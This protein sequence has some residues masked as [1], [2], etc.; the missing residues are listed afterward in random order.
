M[1]KG[2]HLPVGSSYREAFRVMATEQVGPASIWGKKERAYYG[3]AHD[4]NYDIAVSRRKLKVTGTVRERTVAKAITNPKP[5]AGWPPD[6]PR[7]G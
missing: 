7:W 2:F 6:D 5:S 1:A 4:L 3:A